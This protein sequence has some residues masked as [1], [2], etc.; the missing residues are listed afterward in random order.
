GAPAPRDESVVLRGHERRG[1]DPL[2]LG[3]N[4]ALRQRFEGRVALVTGAASG[5][6]RETAVRLAGEGARLVGVDLDEKGLEETARLCGD[7]PFHPIARDLREAAACRA[8]V[9]EATRVA[10]G[11]D[12]L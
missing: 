11:L 4:A 7:A 10:G 1:G 8:V 6:G 5:V 9:A 3:M 2:A 12:A